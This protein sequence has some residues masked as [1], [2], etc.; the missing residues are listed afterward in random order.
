MYQLKYLEGRSNS[1]PGLSSSA[2]ALEKNSRHNYFT[3]I[4]KILKYQKPMFWNQTGRYELVH[5]Y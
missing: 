5:K 3:R 2:C 4:D 1:N